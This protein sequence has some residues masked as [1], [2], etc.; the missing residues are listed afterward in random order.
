MRHQLQATQ[1]AATQSAVSSKTIASF[2]FTERWNSAAP[3][4]IQANRG[5]NAEALRPFRGYSSILH[6]GHRSSS[7]YNALTASMERRFRR[8]L[9][10]QLAYTFSRS[11]DDAS[12]KR[13]VL[14]ITN[15]R[16]ADR[17]LSSFDR[18]NVFYVSY[19]YEVPF[20]RADSAKLLRPVFAGWQLAGL[21]VFQTGLPTSAFIA[22]DTAGVAGGG[23][24]RA[25]VIGN[26]LLP[27]G[28]RAFGR[29]FNTAAFLAPAA[30]TFGNGGRNI[31]RRPGANNWDV[32]ISKNFR[33]QERRTIQLRGEF[34]NIWN[35][36]SYNN[37]ETTLGNAGFGTINGSDP[38]RVIQIA[39]RF[40]F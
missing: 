8:G 9:T 12:D 40:E 24:Q 30:G 23:R 39:A 26:G 18:T 1:E 21:T 3:G 5:V 22:P 6:A 13:D 17:G 14:M 20:F 36:L 16:R 4:T 25:D 2:R 28:D 34:F 32:S 15:N 19:I 35:H 11:I 27:R 31:L 7:N 38:A 29:Y 33:I 10:L 37:I